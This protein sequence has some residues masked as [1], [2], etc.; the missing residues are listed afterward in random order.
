MALF[1]RVFI[2]VLDSSIAEDFTLRHVFEDLFKLCDWRTGVVDM[3]R[4]SIARRLNIPI[5]TLSECI[6]KL[7][8]PDPASRDPDNDGRRLERLDNHRDWGWR[9]LN[10][11]KYDEIRTRAD[12]AQRVQRHRDGKKASS[13]ALPAQAGTGS[14]L[15]ETLNVMKAV[16]PAGPPSG[17]PPTARARGTNRPLSVE[18]VIEAGKMLAIEEALCRKFW[19]H[20]EGTAQD[21]P[22]GQP[23]W[24]TGER[25]EKRVGNWKSILAGWK[26]ND[27]ERRAGN[28]PERRGSNPGGHR[29]PKGQH[30]NPS[31]EA[32][33]EPGPTVVLPVHTFNA[34]TPNTPP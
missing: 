20:Y 19:L 29:F 21:D 10:W 22:S 17:P 4:Q 5:E 33:K 11:K 31:K 6:D 18:E 23:V 3:T 27:E 15:P 7:E 30:S 24:V 1:A 16:L 14:M 13:R 34:S 8:A 2:T 9:I 26:A 25:G 28:L 32:Q 12:V